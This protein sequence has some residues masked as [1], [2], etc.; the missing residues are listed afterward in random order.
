[1][2]IIF[3][4][5]A[6]VYYYFMKWPQYVNHLTFHWEFQPFILFYRLY[7]SNLHI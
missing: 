1:M 2:P 3:T 5:E 6:G 4:S 7:L